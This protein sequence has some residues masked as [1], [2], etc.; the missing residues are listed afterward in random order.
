MIG[1]YRGERKFAAEAANL[2]RRKPDTVV[3]RLGSMIGRGPDHE[4]VQALASHY[5]QVRSAALAAAQC[6]CNPQLMQLHPFPS[7]QV[8]P[9]FN[10]TAKV[11]ELRL[12]GETYTPQELTAMLLQF[13]EGIT[14]AF[15]GSQVRDAAL[16]VPAWYTQSERQAIL[17]A[18]RLADLNVLTL[19]DTSTAVALQWAIDRVYEEEHYV[20]FYDMG[21]GGT[22]VAVAKFYPMADKGKNVSA[23]EVLGKG[24]DEGLGGYTFDL[25]MTEIL[26]DK[27]NRQLSGGDDVRGNSKSMAKL[28]E[29]ARKVK[30]ILSANAEIPVNIEGLHN[31]IDF[32]SHV[33]RAEFEQATRDIVPRVSQP[34]LD[35]LQMAGMNAS[36]I[37]EIELIGGSVRIPAVKAAIE[38]QLKELGWG[39]SGGGFWNRDVTLGQHLNGDEA[40]ALGTAF[41]AANLSTAFRVRKVGL[42][43]KSVY[44]INATLVASEGG[45]GASKGL[46]G[47]LFGSKDKGAKAQEE[48]AWS[49][50]TSLFKAA[51]PVDGR[52]GAK[53][54][55]A[56]TRDHDLF[57]K[58]FYDVGEGSR[59]PAGVDQVLGTYNVTGVAGFAKE[60]ADK[61]LDA[62]KI[63]LTFRLQPSGVM[64]LERAEATVEEVTMPK[65]S[66]AE[67]EEAAAD[68]SDKA[69]DAEAGAAGA[70][71]KTDGAADEAG[72]EGQESGQ[73]NGES[74]DGKDDVEAAKAAEEEEK[75]AEAA[76]ASEKKEK[77][78]KKKKQPSGPKTTVHRR[79]LTVEATNLFMEYPPM[80]EA[81]LKASKAKLDAID[82]ADAARQRREAA[83]NQLEEYILSVRHLV[84]DEMAE[85]VAKV[86]TEEQRD[87]VISTANAAEEWLYEEGFGAEAGVLDGKR[88]EL[89]DLAKPL[90]ERA[91]EHE[92]RP[93]AVKKARTYIEEKTQLM[94]TWSATKPQVTE[95]ERKDVLKKLGDLEEW[96]NGVEEK[97]SK[98]EVHEKPAFHSSEIGPRL[99]SIRSL[100]SRLNK[101]P[102]PAPE[103]PVEPEKPAEEASEAKD[104]ASGDSDEATTAGEAE[105]EGAAGEAR[106]TEGEDGAEEAK[107]G[108]GAPA[109]EL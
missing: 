107:S 35:A 13:S 46:L 78:K 59:F 33:T 31:D 85:K 92:G 89:A 1:F 73:E 52:H 24:W 48:A 16:A 60:M 7:A 32:R 66:P 70:E 90:L 95:D 83:Q 87:E 50:T 26:A 104:A 10:E 88:K 38:K 28:R 44:P 102:K 29:H 99:Q 40:C 91:L 67:D 64:V 84:N 80:T 34:I 19:V 8:L 41:R 69:A 17:D 51:T 11:L 6:P 108:D 103:K 30:E 101:R 68:A 76:K 43:E 57:I 74:A 96:L 56:L 93:K 86:S 65:E 22:E 77:K 21:S 81:Q 54:T 105:A 36:Q 47:G 63:S 82:A 106:E 94:D 9:T 71:A 58:V 15:S 79:S 23:F 61:G 72:K 109:D 3:S 62:P 12:E 100:V 20:L 42:T 45:A 39:S 18:A 5:L 37:H 25:A 14:K 49:K 2:I 97:Q 27:F 53:K 4:I 55:L 98:L 75:A